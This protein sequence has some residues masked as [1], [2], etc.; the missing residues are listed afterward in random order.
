MR[1]LLSAALSLLLSLPVQ[2]PAKA[3][4]EAAPAHCVL[5]E[6]AAGF[7]GGCGKIFDESPVLILASEKTIASSPWREDRK[8]ISAWSGALKNPGDPDFPLEL[9]VYAGGSGILRTEFGWYPLSGFSL[10]DGMGFDLDATHEVA[11]N[12][13]DLKI[14]QRAAALISSDAKWNRKD[15]RVCPDTATTWS[16]YCAMEKATVDVTG[17]PSHRRPAL[18]AVRLIVDERSA[19]RNYDHRLM[20]YNNDPR[21]QLGDVQSLFK[22]A[23]A[24]MQDPAWLKQHGFAASTP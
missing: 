8:P 20:D 3:A 14:M 10:K 12:A 22:E 17:A 1:T 21:T 2:T 23:M 13:L 7:T 9:E 16:I 24:G 19:G 11:P 5:H 15:N 4:D 18:E 6:G